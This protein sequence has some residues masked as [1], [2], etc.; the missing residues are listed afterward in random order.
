MNKNMVKIT[1]TSTVIITSM[2]MIT[3]M[4]SRLVR[5]VISMAATITA[6]IT[7]ADTIMRR[8]RISDALS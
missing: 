5:V 4:N 6:G 2:I 1:D 3:A 7:M 8:L